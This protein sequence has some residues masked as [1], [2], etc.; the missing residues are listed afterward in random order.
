MAHVLS[1]YEWET[2]AGKSAGKKARGRGI[3]SLELFNDGSRW[4]IS[5][6]TWEEERPNNPIPKEFLSIRKK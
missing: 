2:S 3:N 4:W 1:A 5:A 6:V